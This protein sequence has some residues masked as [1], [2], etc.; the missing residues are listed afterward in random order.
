MQP[1]LVAATAQ[2]D[3][4][5]LA[6]IQGKLADY[7]AQKA[8]I[9]TQIQLLQSASIKGSNELVRIADEKDKLLSDGNKAYG[10]AVQRVREVA[11]RV[12]EDMQHLERETR[13][14]S[15]RD[16]VTHSRMHEHLGEYG[17]YQKPESPKKKEP[18]VRNLHTGTFYRSVWTD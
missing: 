17:K 3:A 2:C 7:E 13:Y 15:G 1:A 12:L 9:G 8:A 14:R 10:A 16:C 18:E 11:K 5:G 6:K 4:N